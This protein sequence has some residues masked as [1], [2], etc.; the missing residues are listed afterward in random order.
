MLSR[1]GSSLQNGGGHLDLAAHAD[2][3]TALVSW[4]NDL[5]FCTPGAKDRADSQPVHPSLRSVPPYTHC[6]GP[7][8]VAQ[9]AGH[10]G[11]DQDWTYEVCGAKKKNLYLLCKRARATHVFPDD[12]KLLRSKVK[13]KHRPGC[14]LYFRLRLISLMTM[15]RFVDF[16][17]G[18]I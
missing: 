5:V 15:R 10:G 12:Y 7:A 3:A 13:L 14:A 4:W 17:G 11:R 2:A 6:H 16:G 8:V 18:C 1:S 9:V